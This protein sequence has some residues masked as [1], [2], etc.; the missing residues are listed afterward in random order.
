MKIK[1]DNHPLEWEEIL[2]NTEKLAKA[3]TWFKKDTLDYWRHNH[4]RESIKPLIKTYLLNKWLTV[5]D[6]RFGTDAHYLIEQGIE[7]VTASD[8]SDAL[9][10]IGKEEGFIKDYS[11]Q[12]AEMLSFSDGEFDFVLCK[13]SYHHC[14]RP[15]IALYEMLRVATTAVILIEPTDAKKNTLAFFLKKLLGRSIENHNFEPVGKYV[16]T[17]SISEIEK[18]MLGVGLRY[19]AYKGVNDYYTEGVETTPNEGGTL[20]NLLT[21]IRVKGV[22]FIK[23]IL[24]FLRI[25]NP[26]LLTIIIFKITPEI[27]VIELLEKNGFKFTALPLNPYAS[28]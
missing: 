19:F 28:A 23:N 25:T 20:R 9:L 24:S 4:I 3:R 15:N 6:G 12:N 17:V 26:N 8:I 1:Y 13:E 27:A 16:Y 21:Q 5:G 11:M 7:A 14:P 22:I 2:V 10:K 18:L